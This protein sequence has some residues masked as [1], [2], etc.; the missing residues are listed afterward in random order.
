VSAELERLS[1]RIFELGAHVRRDEVAG[2]DSLE[3]VAL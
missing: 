2:F 1:S 3:A